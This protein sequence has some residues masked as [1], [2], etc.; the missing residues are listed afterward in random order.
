MGC[1]QVVRAS[2]WAKTNSRNDRAGC[3]VTSRTVDATRSSA[4]C[5]MSSSRPANISAMLTCHQA[6][7]RNCAVSLAALRPATQLPQEPPRPAGQAQ[8]PREVRTHRPGPRRPSRGRVW[9]ARS[10]RT[11]PVPGIPGGFAGADAHGGCL[12]TQRGGDPAAGG[13]GPADHQH[14]RLSA[15]TVD[16]SPVKAAVNSS[17]PP[18]ISAPASG[19]Q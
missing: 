2:R 19:L 11:R 7:R 15:H 14:S 13:A 18:R 5:R 16:S 6:P 10:S 8:L 3:P 9:P 12:F 1:H 4:P 17:S